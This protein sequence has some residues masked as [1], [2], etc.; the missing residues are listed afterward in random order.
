MEKRSSGIDGETHKFYCIPVDLEAMIVGNLKS[1]G[2]DS[3]FSEVRKIADN[4][5]LENQKNT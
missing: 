5:Y 1:R 3:S 4:E 2:I